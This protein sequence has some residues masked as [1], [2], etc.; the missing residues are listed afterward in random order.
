MK[1][2]KK[3]NYTLGLPLLLTIYKSKLVK[4]KEDYDNMDSQMAGS[5]EG[6]DQLS[7]IMNNPNIDPSSYEEL[8]EESML[9]S[10]NPPQFSYLHSQ[11]KTSL[12]SESWKGIKVGLNWHPTNMFNT[13]YS[14]TIDKPRGFLKNY[15]INA[16]TIIPGIF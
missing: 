10:I 15:A 3:F 5:M 11:F 14:L 8:M 7:E 12:D 1:L 2:N 16:T 6:F 13:E 9:N 4:S